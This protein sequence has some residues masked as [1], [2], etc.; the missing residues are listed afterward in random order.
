M[1][2]N[3]VLLDTLKR[4]ECSL[5]GSRRKERKWLEQI[6]HEKF[7]EITRSGV[8]VDR[9]QTIEA[10]LGEDNVP[11]ILSSDFRLISAGDNFAIL[12]YR[13]V[14]P[15]GSRASLRSSC[16]EISKNGQWKLVFHQGT[17]EA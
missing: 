3:T 14:N 8:L 9:A 4:L 1:R 13:T 7:S 2:V 6:L 10:L 11:V 12:Y 5:H 15:D 16:W 17:P